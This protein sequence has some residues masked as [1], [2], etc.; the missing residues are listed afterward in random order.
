[1][2]TRY[3]RKPL[4]K[5]IPE[6][7]KTKGMHPGENKPNGFPLHGETFSLDK[8]LELH[9]FETIVILSLVA[10]E[11]AAIFPYSLQVLQ[12]F[13]TYRQQKAE[14][15][16]DKDDSITLFQG[17]S[18]RHAVARTEKQRKQ[19]FQ[20]VSRWKAVYNETPVVF[21]QE[22]GKTRRSIPLNISEMFS[23]TP[24][25][26]SLIS[27]CQTERETDFIHCC[28]TSHLFIISFH[29][30]VALH[31]STAPSDPKN[32]YPEDTKQNSGIRS[33]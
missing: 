10:M 17:L 14:N 24:G 19:S 6:E 15:I 21:I 33:D 4:Q 23:I 27:V 28:T 25:S 22:E 18:R 16:E 13:V 3:Q 20:V 12:F 8:M 29:I 1:M 5:F 9:A 32:G 11:T 30:L 26:I 31:S 7:G 2:E